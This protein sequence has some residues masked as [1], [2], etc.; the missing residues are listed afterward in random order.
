MVPPL[1]SGKRLSIA[2]RVEPGKA[3]NQ[4]LAEL[5]V[6]PVN[7]ETYPGLI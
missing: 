7:Q 1:Y 3:D 5:P 6:R 2:T 4:E